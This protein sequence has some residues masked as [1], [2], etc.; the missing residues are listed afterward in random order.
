MSAAET[1][2]YILT[3]TNANNNKFWEVSISEN[4]QVNSRNGR[5]GSKGQSRSLGQGEALFNRKVR[6]KERKGY[7]QVEIIGA[8]TGGNL[9]AKAIASAAEDQIAKGDP[10]V[11]ELVR[12]LA[13]INR[14]QLMAASG[15]QMDIDLST[16]MVSTPLGV[17]TSDNINKARDVL[18]A[19]TSYVTKEEYEAPFFRDQLERYLMLVP[20]K[21]GSRRGWHREFL[22]SAEDLA[23]Q[24]SL[25]D[26]LETSV[27]IANQRIRDA[28]ESGDAP[29][30]VDIFNVSMRPSDDQD[31]RRKVEDFFQSG[32][33]SMHATRNFRISRIFDVSLGNMD[34]DFEEDGA[35]VGGVM[36]LWHGTRAHNLLSILKSGLIIPKSNGSIQV[37]G[38]MFGNGIY[39][40]D[41][42]TKSLNYS[43]GYWDSG[44]KDNKCYMFLA[45]V[46]MGKPWHPTRTGSNVKP[47]DGY[48]SVYA[49]GG[50]D[51]V[52]NNE[53]IVYR[54]SQAKLK[55][56]VE[57]QQ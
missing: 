53:M 43:Y 2:M 29:K 19:L 41:Q 31:L 50:Q 28:E 35:K 39:F 32:R 5:V 48:D 10:V 25:L 8:P 3:D 30:P 15:G 16:G 54:T 18:D 20:Q 33:K 21:V 47:A 22:T 23:K 37:T 27:D 49:R 9:D 40:S 4:G 12:T 56:L 14:H 42:S 24:G 45:D 13:R 1:R 46:A 6:E 36:Q 57:F 55:Y 17:I 7:V 52:M 34:R 51:V 26:Q 38:R 11:A 44:T